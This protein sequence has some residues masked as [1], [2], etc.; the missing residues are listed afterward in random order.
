MWIG[1]ATAGSSNSSSG[2]GGGRGGW[3][4]SWRGFL[5]ILRTKSA[6]E[7]GCG[8][9][10]TGVRRSVVHRHALA[11]VLFIAANDHRWR[12]AA[13]VRALACDAV[14]IVI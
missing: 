3:L 10:V 8:Y 11:P 14:V 9:P 12:T 5:A 13:A 1:R 2:G 7:V 6:V 4:C